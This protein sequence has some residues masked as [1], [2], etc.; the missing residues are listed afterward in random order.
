MESLIEVEDFPGR[1][2]NTLTWNVF[3]EK[4]I[5]KQLFF[6]NFRILS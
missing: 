1:Y 6:N 5:D 4:Q 2:L 3:A